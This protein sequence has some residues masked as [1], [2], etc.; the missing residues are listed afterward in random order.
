ME[1]QN[2][3]LRRLHDFSTCCM[4]NRDELAIRSGTK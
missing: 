3:R 1:A 4:K 2:L